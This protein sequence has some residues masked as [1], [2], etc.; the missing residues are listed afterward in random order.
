MGNFLYWYE[1]IWFWVHE[2]KRL[3]FP[4]YIYSLIY[5]SVPPPCL[6]GSPAFLQEPNFL[7]PAVHNQ[8][9]GL[10][11]CQSLAI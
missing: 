10:T 6:P 11:L 2:V 8:G 3:G 9:V 7:H 4:F 1:N 5:N